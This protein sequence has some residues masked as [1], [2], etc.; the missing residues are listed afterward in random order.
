MKKTSSYW[1]VLRWIGMAFILLFTSAIHSIGQS[2]PRIIVTAD[3]EL[4][5]SNSLIRFL[6]YSTDFKVEG[7]IYASS[8][9]HWTGDGKGTKFMVPGREY[10]RFGLNLCPCE[11]YRWGKDERFINDIVENY[12]KV[13]TNLKIHNPNYPTPSELKSK[14]RFG[15]IEFD[16]DYS[17]DTPGSDL[18]KSLMLDDNPE[19]LYITAWGG[20][21]TI[22]RALKSIQDQ[23]EKTT[24]WS[25]VR[26][27][28]LN[29]VILLPSLDQDDT[30]AKYI[31]IHWPEIDYRQMG[32]GPNYSYGLQLRTTPENLVYTTASW[33]TANITSRGPLGSYYRV[34]GDGKQMVKGDIFD[35]FGLSG[36]TSEELKKMGYIVW[37][38]VQEKGSWLGE[39]DNP[40][41]MNMLDNGL[42]AYENGSYGGWG[43]K[44]VAPGVG[45]TFPDAT[46]TNNDP[47]FPNFWPS[48]QLDFASRL[49]WSV[50]PRYQDANHEPK[51]S[52]EG[53]L[54]VSARAG[55]KVLLK[56]IV[57]DPD[58]DAVSLKWWQFKTGT[59][60]GDIAIQNP[61]STSTEFVI[62]A[63]A[64]NGQTIHVIL[65]AT[66]NNSLPLTRYQRI[67]ITFSGK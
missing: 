20:Q 10:T 27:K 31:K 47:P 41:F 18:I 59:Y 2:K 4:D 39:G 66:D 17:K 58:G 51:V 32:G 65:E 25:A 11:S 61:S 43:G 54:N 22:A 38:P 53:P 60:Q 1:P 52:I 50:T 14:I 28:V 7:L 40:T 9:F 55:Q 63:D 15:N 64:K 49:K 16:G 56:G 8:Q 33:M 21:S 46:K 42:R 36:Y 26:A 23:Y 5:D 44:Q 67:I 12:E 19:P 62:P 24:E 34:W 45:M 57:S 37:M 30:Y 48:A 29:K 35:Y 3:P 6:L 13:Y